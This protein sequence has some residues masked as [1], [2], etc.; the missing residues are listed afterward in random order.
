MTTPDISVSLHGPTGPPVSSA[1]SGPR[2]RRRDTSAADGFIDG[3]WWPRSLDLS[4]E[5]PPLLAELREAGH[6]VVRVAY[7]RT[8]WNPAPHALAGAGRPVVLDGSTDHDAAAV[9]LVDASGSKR[10]E[11]VVIPPHTDPR[12]AERVLVLA[13]LGGDLRR[14]EGI[15]GRAHRKSAS[16]PGH[17]GPPEP[18]D[19]L[20]PVPTAVWETDG[21]R[22][23]SS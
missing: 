17:A 3:G 14:A 10:T 22:A 5:L 11:L 2:V 9:S 7:N 13:Q 21:G 12:V 19:P 23:L 20:D 6:D 4:V 16:V 8:A 1:S 18:V 15:L